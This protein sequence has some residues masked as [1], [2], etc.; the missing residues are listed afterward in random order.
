MVAAQQPAAAAAIDSTD[1]CGAMLTPRDFVKF[2][3]AL[4]REKSFSLINNILKTV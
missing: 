2:H 3:K 1:R 4:K